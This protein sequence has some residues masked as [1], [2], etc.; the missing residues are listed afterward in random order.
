VKTAL[1]I[2]DESIVV[3]DHFLARAVG[4][5]PTIVDPGQ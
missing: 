5:G 4:S 3:F 1:A 2:N